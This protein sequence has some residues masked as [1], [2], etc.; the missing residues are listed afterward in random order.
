MTK[1]WALLWKCQGESQ[2]LGKALPYHPLPVLPPRNVAFLRVKPGST[3][4]MGVLCY[5]SFTAVS[6]SAKVIQ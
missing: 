1:E 2:D 5:L 3:A 6:T 4:G